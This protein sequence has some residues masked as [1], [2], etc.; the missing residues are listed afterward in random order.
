[1]SFADKILKIKISADEKNNIMHQISNWAKVQM[2]FDKRR[3]DLDDGF[4]LYLE[5][6]LQ[7]EL[8][9]KKREAIIKRLHQG[10]HNI[11]RQT[12]YASL[13]NVIEKPN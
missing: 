9:T 6:C 10:Y 1:M 13:M 7:V 12:Q 11:T 8:T 4:H 3:D 5:K 2:M